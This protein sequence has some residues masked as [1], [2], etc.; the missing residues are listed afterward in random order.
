VQANA[1]GFGGGRGDVACCLFS[2]VGHLTNHSCQPNTAMD[3]VPLAHGSVGAR[4]AEQRCSPKLANVDELVSLKAEPEP[5][6][7]P[8]RAVHTAG[9]RDPPGQRTAD[10]GWWAPTFRARSLRDIA[11]GEELCACYCNPSDGTATRRATLEAHYGFVCQCQRC[12]VAD[13]DEEMTMLE[14][15]EEMRCSSGTSCNGMVAPIM[16][17]GGEWRCL[18]CSHVE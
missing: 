3:S 2:S 11:A 18:T 16:D 5:E 12:M 1:Y 13:F 9:E 8:H 10:D 15:L 7:E 4:C 17:N 6:P 14:E